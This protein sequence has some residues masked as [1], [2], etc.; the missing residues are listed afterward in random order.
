MR[1]DL[2]RSRAWSVLIALFVVFLWATSWVLIK[3]GL[4]DLPALAFA[5]LRYTLAFVCLVPF[6]V[7][8]QRGRVP[9]S[10]SRRTLG[11]LAALGL[12]LYT[13]TQGAIFL[14]L[15]YLPAVT[16]NLLWSFSTVLVALFGILWLSERPLA[17]QW[18][19]I[20]IAALGAVIYF[21]PAPLARGQMAGLLVSV[22]GVLANAGA[23]IL[24]R[25]VNREGVIHPLVVTA[26][27][28]GIGSV[29]L[30]ILG[31]ALQ[32]LPVISVK[33]WA[34]IAW[35]AVMNTA[36]AFSLWNCTLRTLSATES[37]ILNGTM[38]IWVPV[39]AVLFLHESVGVKEIAGLIAAALGTL[40]VQLRSPRALSRLRGRQN[41]R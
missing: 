2:A 34:I 4:A 30:L 10:L 27:S 40:M 19:G 7:A 23:S 22:V 32:G 41:L 13:V 8:T 17:F 1:P 33:G 24:G 5:G 20:A 31:I 28:M 38:M 36:L 39:L 25:R 14:A 15:S 16:V 9:R 18:L 26:A 35:L 11:E 29:A 12:L 6:A 21:H 3:I 37:S